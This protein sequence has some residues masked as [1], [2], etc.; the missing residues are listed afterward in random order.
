MNINILQCPA[1][2]SVIIMSVIMN[3]LIIKSPNLIPLKIVVLA[4]VIML[5]ILCIILDLEFPVISLHYAPNSMCMHYSQDHCQNIL[6][7]LEVILYN[8]C[9]A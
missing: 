8:Y 4:E 2:P 7:M 3:S 1:V 9:N 5:I 6:I